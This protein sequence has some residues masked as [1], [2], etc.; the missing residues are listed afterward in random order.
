MRVSEWV[1]V[2]LSVCVGGRGR[3]SKLMSTQIFLVH[4]DHKK[5]T[6]RELKGEV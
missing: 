6:K 1:C 2:F 5:D 4:L 3:C